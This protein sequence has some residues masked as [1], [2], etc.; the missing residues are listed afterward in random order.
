MIKP[1]YPFNRLEKQLFRQQRHTHT[2]RRAVKAAGIL[3]WPKQ[4]NF[5]ALIL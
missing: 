3:L 4:E 1:R 5:T 2:L